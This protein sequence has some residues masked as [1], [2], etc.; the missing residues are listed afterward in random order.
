M[1]QASIKDSVMT[2]TQESAW[3]LDFDLG[4]IEQVPLHSFNLKHDPLVPRTT[5][6]SS[7]Y[8]H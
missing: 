1:A 8:S 7:V 3:L 4:S 2:L 6:Y 5:S